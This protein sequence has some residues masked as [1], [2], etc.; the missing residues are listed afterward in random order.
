MAVKSCDLSQKCVT[1]TLFI[2][3]AADRMRLPTT[4][5]RMATKAA[6]AAPL[7][8]PNLQ[9]EGHSIRL[10]LDKD[11]HRLDEAAATEIPSKKSAENAKQ[12]EKAGGDK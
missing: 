4:E 6:K 5:V 9:R 1:L 8:A 2:C 7:G 11:F 12:N 10:S 3:F